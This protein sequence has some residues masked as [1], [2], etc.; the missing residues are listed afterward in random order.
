MLLLPSASELLQTLVR[1][2]VV[3]SLLELI[4]LKH[5]NDGNKVLRESRTKKDK[6]DFKTIKSLLRSKINQF[7]CTTD[8]YGLLNIKT[9]RQIPN[10]VSCLMLSK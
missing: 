6:Y 3:N 5:T 2:Q 7:S 9:R 8:K 10:S 1:N 4:N